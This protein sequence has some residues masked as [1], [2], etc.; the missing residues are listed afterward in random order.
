MNLDLFVSDFFVR[1]TCIKK[2]TLIKSYTPEQI[3]ET[4]RCIN[5]LPRKKYDYTTSAELFDD[6]VK[7]QGHCMLFLLQN[8]M[9]SLIIKSLCAFNI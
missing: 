1:G 9:Y 5:N 6:F 8:V 2:G 7:K 3:T 4:E